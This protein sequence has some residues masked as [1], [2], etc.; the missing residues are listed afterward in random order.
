MAFQTSYRVEAESK[1]LVYGTLVHN[2]IERGWSPLYPVDMLLFHCPLEVVALDL[3]ACVCRPETGKWR[4]LD[5][6]RGQILI[7][8]FYL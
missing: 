1:M 7:I 5:T 6:V 8:H 2:Q 4:N 3:K